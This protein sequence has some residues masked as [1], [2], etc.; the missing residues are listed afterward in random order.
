MQKEQKLRVWWVINPPNKI[1]L[2]SVLNIE[3]A[4]L[5]LNIL[6]YLDLEGQESRIFDLDE[7]RRPF[8]ERVASAYKIYRR[9]LSLNGAWLIDCN[10][11]GLQ[12]WDEQLEEWV[13]WYSEDGETI[14]EIE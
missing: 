7:N 11:G 4:K 14:G 13:E 3:S 5:V 9:S 10:A 8:I 1:F 12:E 6:A 2:F